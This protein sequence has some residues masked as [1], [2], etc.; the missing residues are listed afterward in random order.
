MYSIHSIHSILSFGG[1]LAI[2]NNQDCVDAVFAP[3]V[4]EL[5]Y[6][7]YLDFLQGFEC[8][9]FM[10][11]LSHE[12]K[13][14][15]MAVFS[16]CKALALHCCN[17]VLFRV[18]GYTPMAVHQV[19]VVFGKPGAGKSSLIEPLKG[20]VVSANRRTMMFA[21][22]NGIINIDE[23][24][25]FQS[26][27]TGKPESKKKNKNKNSQ[28][29]SDTPVNYSVN[30]DLNESFNSVFDEDDEEELISEDE[31]DMQQR[32]EALWQ[33]YGENMERAGYAAPRHIDIHNRR[34]NETISSRIIPKRR[35]GSVCCQ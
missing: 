27:F 24:I 35:M 9:K 26:W 8:K 17:N 33:M 21:K 30:L 12:L 1:V 31:Q 3:L 4:E 14:N 7:A 18:P 15:A 5:V 19:V 25:R 16:I 28:N 10:M 6:D 34:Q 23:F 11:D 32:Q 20:A 2:M 22:R 29:S 13:G